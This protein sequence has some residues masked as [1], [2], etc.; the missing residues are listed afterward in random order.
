MCRIFFASALCLSAI[1]VS[2]ALEDSGLNH[3]A[4]SCF[5]GAVSR[6]YLGQTT[7]AGV[8]T[9]AQWRAFVAESLTP[10]FPAGFTELQAQGHWRDDRGTVIEED[11]RIVEVVHDG[12]QLTRERVRAVATDYRHR[13]AQ[14]S[15]LVTQ[16]ASFQCF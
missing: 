9:E 14:Q 11:T 5:E 8:V 1:T 3:P 16:A 2:P 12:A 6:L 4:S 10:R 15:V 13:F 7:P